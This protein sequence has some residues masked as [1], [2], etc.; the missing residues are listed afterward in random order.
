MAIDSPWLRLNADWWQSEMI[1]GLRYPVNLLWPVVLSHFKS[2]GNNRGKCK[3][4]PLI[5]F[6]RLYG[7]PLADTEELFAAA[8]AGERPAMIEQD[9]DWYLTSWE[10][11][12]SQDAIRKRN[13]RAQEGIQEPEEDVT[14]NAD[15]SRTNEECHGQGEIVTDNADLSGRLSRDR[16]VTGQNRTKT[17]IAPPS[18]RDPVLDFCD[19]AIA[20][21][22]SLPKWKTEPVAR[23]D[24]AN[25]ERQFVSVFGPERF[26]E[27]DKFTAFYRNKSPTPNDRPFAVALMQWAQS[28]QKKRAKDASQKGKLKHGTTDVREIYDRL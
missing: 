3:A 8:M 19:A 23:A 12:Q 17:E 25:A 20:A 16:T 21:A 4:L 15:L 27:L 14:D 9:G 10:E 22:A 13:Q 6:A 26:D 18:A 2:H 7:M 24:L 28:G 1:V 11:Y 5:V